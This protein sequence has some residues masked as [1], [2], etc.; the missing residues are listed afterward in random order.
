MRDRLE[1]LAPFISEDAR[2][3]LQAKSHV[4]RRSVG[5]HGM[6]VGLA[7]WPNAPEPTFTELRLRVCEI[8]NGW[9]TATATN[10]SGSVRLGFSFDFPSGK[11]HIDFDKLS[12]QLSSDPVTVDDAVALVQLRKQVIGNGRVELWL[13]DGGRLDFEVVIPVNI[14]IAGTWKNMDAEIAELRRHPINTNPPIDSA[15]DEA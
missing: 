13:S 9:L 11:A 12:Y 10:A 3:A 2:Q 7:R 14:D 6:T 4:S 8:R 1:S 5:I 15:P